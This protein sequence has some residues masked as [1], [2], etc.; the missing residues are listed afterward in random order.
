MPESL[1]H[2]GTGVGNAIPF[3]VM[4]SGLA[5]AHGQPGPMS[6]SKD[7]PGVLCRAGQMAISHIRGFVSQSNH[8]TWSRSQ[9]GN[10]KIVVAE[11]E[12]LT[13]T[14]ASGAFHAGNPA[15]LLHIAV[16]KQFEYYVA[17]SRPQSLCKMLRYMADIRRDLAFDIPISHEVDRIPVIRSK[18]DILLAG[19]LAGYLF[20]PG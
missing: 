6:I 14:P 15:C 5:D 12:S 3:A 1:S 11:A 20:R 9:A 10:K 2:K 4:T 13:R 19:E 16:R 17:R 8:P 18:L 7:L